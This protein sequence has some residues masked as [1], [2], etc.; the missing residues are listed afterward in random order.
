MNPKLRRGSDIHDRA[1]EELHKLGADYVRF[2]PWFPYPH[3]A[4][5]ELYPPKDGKT[6]WNFEGPDCFTV[7]FL[8]ATKGHPSDVEFQHDPALDV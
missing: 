4:I 2:V 8:E 3:D 1:F 6:S 7:D 5:V